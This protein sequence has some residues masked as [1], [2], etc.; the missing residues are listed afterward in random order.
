MLGR[1]W[2]EQAGSIGVLEHGEHKIVIHGIPVRPC[3][4]P[5]GYLLH[6]EHYI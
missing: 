3:M 2:Q 6:K 5:L 1:I 4:L